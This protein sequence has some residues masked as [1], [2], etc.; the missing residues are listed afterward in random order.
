MA[1]VPDMTTSR[2]NEITI[3]AKV[4]PGSSRTEFA[5]YQGEMYR[6]KV[7]AA[8]EKGRA[9]KA[10]IDYLAGIFNIKKND[11]QIQSGQTSRIKQILLRGVSCQDVQTQFTKKQ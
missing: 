11:I 1:A 8:P 6:F 10:L 5:G 2:N 4:V 3:T 9:N 7:A